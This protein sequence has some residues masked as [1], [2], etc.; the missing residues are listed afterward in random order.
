MTA[1]ALGNGLR[2]A[3]GTLTVLRV[4]PPSRVDRP[5][6][7]VA[8][9]TGWLVVLPVAVVVALVVRGGAD[10][11]AP[12]LLVAALALGALALSSRGLHLD[13]LADTADGLASGHDRERARHV[14]QSGDVGPAGA[15]TLLL[16]LLVQASSVAALVE[17]PLLVAA[18]VL[19]SRAMLALACARGVPS[20]RP[21]GLGAAVAGSVPRAVA[22]AVVLVVAAA[23]AVAGSLDAAVWWIGPAGVA[24]ALAATAVVL[25]RCTSRL[26]G[27]TG[28]VLGAVVEL[29]LAGSLAVAAVAV[30]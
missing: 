23:A 27:V 13:G 22:A 30:A 11:G 8:M 19:V 17:R 26:G 25:R 7:G 6:A 12:P 4:R 9:A 28:D 18:C 5:I 10:L 21:D 1:A 15:T 3:T 24:G 29:A 20:A 14:M 2:L 16:V